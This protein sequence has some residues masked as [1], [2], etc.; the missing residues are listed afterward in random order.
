MGHNES[1]AHSTSR[2]APS[3][4]A[5][6]PCGVRVYAIG[7]IHGRL[8]PLVSLLELVRRDAA[9]ES[10]DRR[11]LVFLGDYVDRGQQSRQVID[12]L[13]DDPAPGFETVFLK[14]NHEAWL[15]AFLENASV[16]EHWFACGGHATLLSYGIPHPA[17]APTAKSLEASREALAAAM[18]EKHKTFLSGLANAHAEGGYAFVHAGIRPGVALAD[19]REEDLLWGS[20]DFVEDERDHGKVIVHGH[21][22]APEPVVRRNRIGID[23]GAFA[24]GRLTCLALWGASRKFLST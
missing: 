14:G 10:A 4:A 15:L 6:V 19:Q 21:W 22:W 16:G 12:F 24:S 9:R 5:S 13:L 17:R 20:A 1:M 2:P 7:D 3:A 8:E 23:T 11:V 18:P